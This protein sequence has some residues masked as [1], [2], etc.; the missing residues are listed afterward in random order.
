MRRSDA[1]QDEV[2]RLAPIR[3][4]KILAGEDDTGRTADLHLDRAGRQPAVAADAIGDDRVSVLVGDI[5]VEV[6][7]LVV[8]EPHGADTLAWIGETGTRRNVGKPSLLVHEQR[9]RAIAKRD[10]EIEVSIG[11]DIDPCRLAHGGFF[12]DEQVMD[13]W[14][15]AVRALDPLTGEMKWEHRLFRPPWAGLLSTAG[16]LIFA[17]T[18]DGYFKALDARTG[19][20]LWHMNLGGR[21]IASPMS[22]GVDGE[23]RIAIAAGSALFVF[24][25]E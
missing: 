4:G 20:E 11:I 25:I 3:D 6:A 16:G 5:E 10:K 14:Y 21:V 17:G 12:N 15:G 1:P 9:V 24:G 13:D 19:A 23:Q 7:V 8:I 22:F 2:M 18:E